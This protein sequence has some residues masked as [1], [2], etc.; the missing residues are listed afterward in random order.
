[1]GG[2]Q[3]VRIW[4]IVLAVATT[5]QQNTSFNEYT[6]LETLDSQTT[7][8]ETIKLLPKETIKLLPKLETKRINNLEMLLPGSLNALHDVKREN[9]CERPLNLYIQLTSNM[10][11]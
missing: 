11:S 9:R 7:S 10:F 3:F 2:I 6:L 8:E 1:M 5:Y 4:N